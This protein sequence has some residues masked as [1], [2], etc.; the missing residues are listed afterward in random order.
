M[1]VNLHN[2]DSRF[3]T[4]EAM[5]TRWM[6]T[7]WGCT[8]RDSTCI[9]KEVIQQTQVFEQLFSRFVKTSYVCLLSGRVGIFE[10][11]PDF[12]NILLLYK[13]LYIL[14]QKKFTPLIGSVLNDLGYDMKYSLT[15]KATIHNPFDFLEVVDVVDECTIEL[16][17][18]VF[19]DFG[20]IGKGYLID[21]I[22]SWLRLN[23]CQ[24][25]LVDGSGDLF[26]E[27][28][29][30]EIRIGLE[31]PNDPKKVIG[32]ATLKNG[33]LCG[34]GCSRRSWGEYHHIIDPLSL[35]SP[36][37]ILATWVTADSAALADGLA[38]CLFLSDPKNFQ[39]DIAFEYC[40]LNSAYTI[41]YSTGFPAEYF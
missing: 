22:S 21:K 10:V 14:S 26:Y 31:H 12:C 7:L 24:R 33:A 3:F 19:F 11:P 6:I 17:E 20:G 36:K 30:E 28:N 4:Y 13:K 37:D 18:S 34:S 5:G 35:R 40:M 27:G 25:F 9:E 38:T 23:G 32:V 16:K 29:G 1:G 39:E 2:M 8:A 41:K 15:P